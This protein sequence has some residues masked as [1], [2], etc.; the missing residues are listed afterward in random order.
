MLPYSGL[1]HS[2]F[3][4]RQHCCYFSLILLQFDARPFVV[5]LFRGRLIYLG[6]IYDS[7][8]LSQEMLSYAV[9]MY[10]SIGAGTFWRWYIWW[11]SGLIV[12]YLMSSRGPGFLNIQNNNIATCSW[13]FVYRGWMWNTCPRTVLPLPWYGPLAQTCE[14]PT[15]VPGLA[16]VY[17]F[18]RCV[19]VEGG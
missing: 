6:L 10:N 1:E 9:F 14:R 5:W 12:R 18:F 15:H 4:V 3:G 7:M 19:L 16:L 11:Y 17:S 13:S 2:W 8:F